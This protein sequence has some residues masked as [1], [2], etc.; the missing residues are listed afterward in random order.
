MISWVKLNMQK[1]KY[2]FVDNI[3]LVSLKLLEKYNYIV[4][5]K[6]WP[7]TSPISE[8]ILWKV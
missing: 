3:Y 5:N 1:D 4:I 8:N 2:L 6:Y 7:Q